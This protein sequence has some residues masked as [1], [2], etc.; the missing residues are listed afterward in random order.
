MDRRE[1]TLLLTGVQVRPRRD[2][3]SEDKRSKVGM[4]EEDRVQTLW[5]G[6]AAP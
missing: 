1:N 3:G 4:E 5:P 6:E 2:V